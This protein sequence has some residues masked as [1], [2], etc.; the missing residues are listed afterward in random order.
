[1]PNWMEDLSKDLRQTLR[2]LRANPLF[3][4]VAIATL[5]LGIGANTA[6]FSVINAVVLRSL[7]VHDP[8]Q[9]F[10]L[11]TEP[12]QPSGAGNTG[13][14]ESSFSEYVFEQLRQDHRV[15]SDVVAYVPMGF[16]RI[17]VRAGKVPEEVAGEMVSGNYFSGLGV[18][19]ECGRLLSPADERDHNSTVVL[20]YGYWNRSF[21]HDC[22]VVG[23]SISI[24]GV[25]FTIAGIAG[26]RFIGLNGNPTDLWIPLQTRPDFNAW[27]SQEENYYADLNWWCLPLAAR[28]RP[29]VT[30]AQAEA[31]MQPAFLHAAYEHLGGKP[32]RGEKPPTLRL[33]DARGLSGY[34][35]AY[36]KPLTILLVMVA[37]VL[38]IACGNISMLLAARNAARQRE[39]GIRLALGGSR[40]RLFRQLLVESFVLVAGGALLGCLFAFM[41]THALASWSEIQASLTPDRRV[42]LFTLGISLLAGFIFGLAPLIGLARISVSETLKTSGSTAFRSLSRVRT[43]NLTAVLQVALCLV[44]LISTALLVRTLRNLE[45]VNLGM[46]TPGLF[47]FGINPH[48]QANSDSST[49]TFYRTLTDRLRALPEVESVTLMGNR[50]GSGWSNNTGAI[51]DG[52]DPHPGQHSPMRW[53]NVGPDYFKTLGIPILAGRDIS[54]ADGPKSAKVAVVNSTFVKRYLNG[55]AALGH[56]VSFTPRTAFTIVGVVADS[57]YRGITEEP[58]PMAYFPYVQVEGVGAMHFELRTR[59]NPQAIVP[60]VQKIVSDFGPDLALLQPMTQQAQ[61]DD[62]IS[63]E[64]L[65]ARLS[66]FFGL[67]AVVLVGTGL[68]GTIAYG[69]SR[70][71]S[72]LGIRIALGAERPR[73]LW[74][75]LREGLQ[76]SFFGILIGLPLAFA[77]T[78]VLSSLLYGLKPSDPLSI[79]AAAFGIIAI[80]AAACFIPAQ[81]AASVSPIA[82]LRNE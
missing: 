66:I 12:N 48:V 40:G 23:R 63:F 68:Y 57:K 56:T 80:T 24:K 8:E 50:I 19:P 31:A 1:M 47:V 53:N 30:Q 81:R 46:R 55:W 62:T 72:E 69:V 61:F 20:S 49:I 29:G 78:R 79:C 26:H 73:L 27:G 58:I 64:R 4:L 59:G 32:R 67:L 10:F 37:A 42:L 9:V 39:F 70:R 74:M 18:Q 38:V 52:K 21:G 76:L 25:P 75:V 6:I 71:T 65:T 43:G 3:A 14:S 2:G 51:L 15:F 16:N 7:P 22:N 77:S 28:L 5:A 17:A 34:R 11:R 41:A 33:A 13:D 36:E 35:E 82:A 54:D 45:N 44:L 60:L